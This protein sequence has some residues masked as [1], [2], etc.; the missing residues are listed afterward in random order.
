MT[1]TTSAKPNGRIEQERQR[2]RRRED[3]GFGRMRNLTV[4]GDLDPNYVYR[5]INAD[6][7]RITQLT[8][9]DDWDVVTHLAHDDKDKGVGSALERVVDKRTGM[10]AVLVRKP[11]DY[12]EADKA[13]E[14]EALIQTETHIKRGGSPG[15]GGL[16]GP[17]AYVPSGGI[18]IQNPGKPS[19]YTP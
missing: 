11:R 16:T 17:E 4:A 19:N 18:T 1:T 6:P 13:R 5:W 8:K 12:Y 2:R 10:R 7:G 3:P 9:E 15:N 14:Q